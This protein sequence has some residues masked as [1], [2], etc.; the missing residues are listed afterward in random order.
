MADSFPYPGAGEGTAG[1]YIHI[2]FCRSK[3]PYCSFDSQ[4]GCGA[5]VLTGYLAALKDQ[6]RRMAAC[7]WAAKQEFSSVFIGGG[8]PTMYDSDQLGGLLAHCLELFNFTSEV[9]VSIEANPNSLDDAKLRSLRRAGFNRLSIG[10]QSFDDR[11]LR[12]LGRSHDTAE[13]LRAAA[14]AKAAGFDNLSLDLMYGLPG[15][16]LA[17]WRATLETGLNLMPAHFSLY[18]LTVE[19]GT[20][21]GDLAAAGKLKLPDEE[22]V[23]AMSALCREIL[24]SRGY[25]QYEISNYARPGFRCSHNVN[26][27]QNGAYLG[28]GAGAV[29]CLS[30][31]RVKNIVDPQRFCVLLASGIDPFGEAEGLDCQSR[32]RETVV[33]GLRMLAGVS[34]RSLEQR[35]GIDVERYYGGTLVRL[36]GQSMLTLKGDRLCLTARGMEL[37]NRVLAELV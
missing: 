5:E 8:T 32:F 16:A 35:F 11:L 37:A 17:D 28:L 27:W 20:P 33:M 19:E 14:L 1:L 13:G 25:E 6:A 34:C 29:S 2:P 10:M 15:Q 26:Y 23:A 21:F 18:E 24:D 12:M 7:D 22:T 3:C 4:P 9:E 36:I 31:L 30:G